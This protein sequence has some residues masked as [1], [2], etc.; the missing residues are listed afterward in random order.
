VVYR[1]RCLSVTVTQDQVTYRLAEGD[2]LYIR[3]H[4][5]QVIVGDDELTLDI[6]PGPKPDP[7]EQPTGREPRRRGM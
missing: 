3:H 4:G 1:G 5:R 2:P 6:P 7:V